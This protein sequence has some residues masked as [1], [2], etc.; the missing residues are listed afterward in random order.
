MHQDRNG[1]LSVGEKVGGG[2]QGWRSGQLCP[3][4]RVTAGDHRCV[5]L[6]ME[7]EQR[8]FLW[9]PEIPICQTASFI[10]MDRTQNVNM[11]TIHVYVKMLM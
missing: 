3:V 5:P 10:Y 8:E 11:L 6:R 1:T 4:P 9:M 7:R 2:A